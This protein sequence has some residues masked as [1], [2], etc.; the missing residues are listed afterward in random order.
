M[1]VSEVH[2]CHKDRQRTERVRQK[3]LV[4]IFFPAACSVVV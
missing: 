2:C 4:I 3:Q 1:A